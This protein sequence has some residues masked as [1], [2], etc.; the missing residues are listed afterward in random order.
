MERLEPILQREKDKE[1]KEN[2]KNSLIFFAIVFIGVVIFSLA[3]SRF[4]S[5]YDRT[6][7][8]IEMYEFEDIQ[9]NNINYLNLEDKEL[10]FDTNVSGFSRQRAN[11]NFLNF[12]M[13]GKLSERNPSR[14]EIIIPESCNDEG[15]CGA[16]FEDSIYISKVKPNLE[17]IREYCECEEYSEEDESKETCLKYLCVDKYVV[18]VT[19][20]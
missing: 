2:Q 15:I 8:K 18:E 6:D 13:D 12:C 14:C 9:F 17:K 5:K 4:F 11:Y 19:L 16:T 3:T 20:R 10:F 7:P 1:N